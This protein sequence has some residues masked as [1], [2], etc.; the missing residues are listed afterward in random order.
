MR[1]LPVLAAI[2]II[3]AYTLLLAQPPSTTPTTV[4]TTRPTKRLGIRLTD[5]SHY[6]RGQEV[7]RAL[8]GNL[9]VNDVFPGSRAE[10]MGLKRLDAIKRI[11]D[12]DMST[13]E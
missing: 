6:E 7:I 12:K 5:E 2:C 13:L 1:R 3:S 4:S 9:I 10:K 8:G 11:N